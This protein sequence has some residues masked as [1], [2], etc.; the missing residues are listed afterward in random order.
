M[1]EKYLIPEIKIEELIKADVLCASK[2]YNING[3]FNDMF[4]KVAL[5][6]LL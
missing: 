5:E 2:P 1:K 3:K 6:D 4:K